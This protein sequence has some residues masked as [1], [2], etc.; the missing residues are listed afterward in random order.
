MLYEYV[1]EPNTDYYRTLYTTSCKEEQAVSTGGTRH[2]ILLVDNFKNKIIIINKL[3]IDS[4]EAINIKGEDIDAQF[5]IPDKYTEC[6][7]EEN[8]NI[9]E[10]V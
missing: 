5:S 9:G 4:G 10:S 6:E 3:L 7:E 1:F 2:K 8:V